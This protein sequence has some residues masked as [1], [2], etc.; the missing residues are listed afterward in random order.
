MQTIG[1]HQI[2]KWQAAENELQARTRIPG[3]LGGRAEGINTEG[4]ISEHLVSV[5][6]LSLLMSGFARNSLMVEQKALTRGRILLSD[7]LHD[8]SWKPQRSAPTGILRRAG[9]FA[10]VRIN[11]CGRTRLLTRAY[12]HF[13]GPEM[14]SKESHNDRRVIVISG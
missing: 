5:P 7:T 6:D 3:L 14:E 8:S 2:L 9:I 13:I 1:P 4:T 11:T 12:M 10:W